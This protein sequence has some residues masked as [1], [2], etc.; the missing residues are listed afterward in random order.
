MELVNICWS[1]SLL[2]YSN[3]NSLLAS[4]PH[5]PPVLS[6]KAS[7]YIDLTSVTN[8]W[9]LICPVTLRRHKKLK[10]VHDDDEQVSHDMHHDYG[11]VHREIF[12]RLYDSCLPADADNQSNTGRTNDNYKTVPAI[13]ANFYGPFIK[14]IQ[15][16]PG[17]A[18]LNR[19]TKMFTV[20][21][22]KF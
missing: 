10:S 18:T 9:D 7:C 6:E 13:S 16:I 21:S 12:L 5:W 14:Y 20:L 15:L 8:S 19:Q 2:F 22:R 11:F 3:Q 1:V 17:T 4:L